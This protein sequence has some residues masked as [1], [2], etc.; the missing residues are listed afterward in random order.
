[1]RRTWRE[2][3]GI[4]RRR[5][6]TAYLEIFIASTGKKGGASF[7]SAGSK[8]KSTPGESDGLE[9]PVPDGM[10]EEALPQETRGKASYTVY[11]NKKAISVLLKDR[12]FFSRLVREGDKQRVPWADHGSIADAWKYAME[13]TL[14]SQVTAKSKAAET[15]KPK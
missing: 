9:L 5:T 1:M 4:R 13:G 6:T 15:A 7:C 11:C 2:L 14:K 12:A 10:P 8:K 3:R